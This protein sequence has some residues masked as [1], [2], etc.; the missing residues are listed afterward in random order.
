MKV[1]RHILLWLLAFLGLLGVYF[2]LPEAPQPVTITQ[3]QLPKKKSANTPKKGKEASTTSP[4]PTAK[5]EGQVLAP[6][7]R[8]N[9]PKSPYVFPYDMD[10]PNKKH[11]LPKILNEVSGIVPTPN[12]LPNAIA[13]VQDE[14][15]EIYW[16]NATQDKIVA[17]LKF[18][19]KGDY[20]DIALVKQQLYILR[21]D[22]HLYQL[23]L[24]AK[25]NK[26]GN[27]KAKSI[28]TQLPK[29]LDAE[30]LCYWPAKKQLLI[31]CKA[32]F[33][34]HKKAI[35]AY[36]LSQQKLQEKPL[37]I[38][39]QAVLGQLLANNNSKRSSPTFFQ[40]SGI[41]VHPLTQELYLISANHPMLLVLSPNAQTVKHLQHL[42]AK[43]F[44]QAEGICFM[45]NGDL[46]IANEGRNG[47]GTILVFNQ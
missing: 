37:K 35:F 47:K 27:L 25:R 43:Q 21:S 11:T 38:L 34:P 16:Y 42:P 14:K 32:N 5:K 22:G 2:L 44:K 41:A 26:K 40:P 17:H 39:D 10:K 33:A 28:K 15:G 12:Y 3:E 45:P 7:T 23:D 1:Q 9:I 36:D 24:S 31:A 4:Q 13:C 6:N 30:G 20:E 29:H 46:L 8:N 18:G 19:K